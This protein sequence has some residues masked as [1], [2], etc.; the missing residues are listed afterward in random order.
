MFKKQAKGATEKRK[1]GSSLSGLLWMLFGAILTIML[2]VFL[3]LSPFT[4]FSPSKNKNTDAQTQVQP[5]GTD[6]KKLNYEFYDVL[7]DQEMVTI[8]EASVTGEPSGETGTLPAKPDVVVTEN[9][10]NRPQSLD[11]N[12]ATYGISEATMLNPEAANDA[13]TQDETQIEIVEEAGTYDGVE[14]NAAAQSQTDK[15]NETY[16]LQINSFDNADDA[17]TRRAQVLMAGVDSKV[18]KMVTAN[19]QTIYQVISTP[20]KSRQAVTVAQQRLQHS[21]IDSIIVEQRR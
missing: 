11:A 18:V 7:P 15:P 19:D 8:P 1:K 21:G 16:I 10:K 4:D 5:I 3:Y 14:D 2:F 6:V 20:M 13:A 9:T 17:D 12:T